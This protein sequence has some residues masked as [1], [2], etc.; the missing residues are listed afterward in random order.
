MLHPQIRCNPQVRHGPVSIIIEM[1][2]RRDRLRAHLGAP[3]LLL[4]LA[5]GCAT[6]RPHVDAALR[7]SRAAGHP[8]SAYSVACPDILNLQVRGHPEW[9]GPHEVGPDGCVAL[10]DI[11]PLRVAGLTPG[12]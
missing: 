4:A 9:T 11:S 7:S 12:E 5:T 3:A 6:N 10:D 1:G 8:T 2:D